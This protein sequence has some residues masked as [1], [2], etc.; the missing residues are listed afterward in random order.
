[1]VSLLKRDMS[2]RLHNIIRMAIWLNMF[3]IMKGTC[4]REK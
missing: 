1:M 4:K 2:E 3:S